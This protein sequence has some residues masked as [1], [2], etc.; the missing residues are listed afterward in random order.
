MPWKYFTED[1]FIEVVV[2]PNF[3]GDLTAMAIERPVWI[4]ETEQT[5]PGIDASLAV[6]ASRDLYSVNRCPFLY[7]SER[8][9][10]LFEILGELDEH[11]GPY[12]GVIVHGLPAD[13]MLRSKLEE[14]GF[15]VVR[16]SLNDFVAELDP[17]VRGRLLGRHYSE[18]DRSWG[19]PRR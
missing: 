3:S 11:Y 17:V 6:G 1:G 4:V 18:G 13:L 8:E 10:N 12:K 7:P 2:D 14:G 19:R 15:R 16:S 5:Q 9:H